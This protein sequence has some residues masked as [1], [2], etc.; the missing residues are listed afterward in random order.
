MAEESDTAGRRQILIVDD[1]LEFAES[2]VDILAPHGYAPI[3]ADRAETAM[4]AAKRYLPAVAIV[5]VRLGGSSGVDLMARLKTDRPDLVVVMM[6]AHA[7]TQTAIIALR[8]GAYDY[9][10]KSCEPAELLAVLDR[11]YERQRLEAENR[12]AYDTLRAAKEAAETAN[13][14]KSEFLANISHELRTPLNAI[15]G[16]SELM[17]NGSHGPIGNGTYHAYINDIFEA[18]TDLLKIINEILDLSKAEAGK[19]ELLEESVDVANLVRTVTRLVGSRAEEAGLTLESVLPDAPPLVFCDRLKL[20]QILLNLV[21]NAIKFTHPGGRIVITVTADMEQGLV[22]AVRDNGIGIA[23]ADIPRVLQPFVQVD[24]ALSRAHNGTGLGL[25]LVAAMTELHGGQMTI[26]S[27][28]GKGTTVTVIFPAERIIGIEDIASALFGAISEP[29][30]P[31]PAPS[32]SEAD[33]PA[34]TPLLRQAQ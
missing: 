24:N 33:S 18:G 16:F 15:I 31:D 6:T 30:L 23:E 8:R 7:E 10:D 3:L 11:A 13:R 2:I 14:A 19:L 27:E 28:L 22:I 21:S 25:P 5:D 12:S 32:P 26:T 9:C 29:P 4:I 20:K 17:I 34:D 1:D